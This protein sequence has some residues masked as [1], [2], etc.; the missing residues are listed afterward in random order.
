MIPII[1][2]LVPAILIRYANKK[3]LAWWPAIA[4]GLMILPL[5]MLLLDSLEVTT[6]QATNLAGAIGAFSIW[7]LRYGDKPP[8][9]NNK[10][11]EVPTKVPLIDSK[12]PHTK[13]PVITKDQRRK[14]QVLADSLVILYKEVSPSSDHLNLLNRD[15]FSHQKQTNY[16][17]FHKTIHVFIAYEYLVENIGKDVALKFLEHFEQRLADQ[18][19]LGV[20]QLYHN[21]ISRMMKVVQD[22]EENHGIKDALWVLADD[23]INAMS[24]TAVTS[25]V[26]YQDYLQIE[27]DRLNIFMRLHLK[28]FD[29]KKVHAN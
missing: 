21:K 3:P 28:G 11:K 14:L 24:L 1:I 5:A 25:E 17:A 7:V 19:S 9:E 18:V 10:P 8:K 15:G 6:R 2:S 29:N 26:L 22:H 20:C 4:L 12:G 23:V 27:R 16:I 13:P